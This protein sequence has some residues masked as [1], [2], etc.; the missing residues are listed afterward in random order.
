MRRAPLLALAA[1]PWL[2]LGC[3]LIVPGEVPAFHCTGSKPSSCPSG[4]SCDEAT[5][6]CV[7]PG[8]IVDAGEDEEGDEEP[9][10]PDA[11]AADGA[12]VPSS[13]GGGCVGDRDCESDLLC[14]TQTIL[15]S[16]IVLSEASAICTKPC[17]TS[18]DC[19][20]AFVCFGAGTGGNYCVPAT[21]AERS[22]GGAK[23]PGQT[24]SG[25]GDCRSGLCYAGRCLDTCCSKADCT[26]GTTCRV[27]AV[28]APAPSRETWACALPEAGGELGD[29]VA[30]S[31]TPLK[32]ETDN[33]SGTPPR[34]RPSCCSTAGCA[35]L[36]PGTVC[37]YGEFFDS[38]SDAKWCID[39]EHGTAALGDPCS[40][41][42]DCASRFC[43]LGTKRCA[44]VCCTDDDCP[45]DLV[46][47]PSPVGRPLLR[48]TSAR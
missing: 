20:A 27:K 6:L 39:S 18:A 11:D 33:C 10:T 35:A 1:A 42:L 3:S 5:L 43:D 4:M 45:G 22:P 24:C 44:A 8:P 17:C 12:R 2:V 30:C 36:V 29:G 38:N 19:P 48:C 9:I 32:C 26:T 40:G 25:D 46:C 21:A 41:N 34:C 7:V 47:R 13:L 15:S 28:A 37:A 14:G 31:G 16:A 23:K